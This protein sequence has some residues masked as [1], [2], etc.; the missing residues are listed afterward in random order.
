MQ[1]MDV[2]IGL[3]VEELLRVGLRVQIPEQFAV[4]YFII[5]AVVRTAVPDVCV[6]GLI[7]HAVEQRFA[8]GL[9]HVPGVDGGEGE[10]V[11]V[12]HMVDGKLQQRASGIIVVCS[13]FDLILSGG[14]AAT[15]RI[16]GQRTVLEGG[17]QR[18]QV[19]ENPALLGH[20][21]PCISFLQVR[22]TGMDG[23]GDGIFPPDDIVGV[24]GDTLLDV[25]VP[26]HTDHVIRPFAVEADDVVLPFRTALVNM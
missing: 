8:I 4:G 1:H 5:A 23:P 25:S 9:D 21:D 26:D 16:N 7:G 11:F 2:M 19:I 10:A 3:G 13:R 6:P 14:K 20:R 17:T 24:T 15:V 22:L 18:Q 12:R